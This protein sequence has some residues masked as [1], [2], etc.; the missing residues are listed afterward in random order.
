M[1]RFVETTKNFCFK[2]GG[3]SSL[4]D[5]GCLR[6]DEVDCSAAAFSAA[7][8]CLTS[9]AIKAFI[10]GVSVAAAGVALGDGATWS[11]LLACWFS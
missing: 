8:C 4:P 1:S 10:S 7:I 3:T 6:F 9:S 11:S 2:T 5:A